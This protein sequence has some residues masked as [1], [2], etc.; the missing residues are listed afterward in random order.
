MAA[1][2]DD[3]L[4]ADVS[5]ARAAWEQ[6]GLQARLAVLK[7]AGAAL[8]AH[9]EA[10][11]ATLLRDGLSRAMARTY[12]DWIVRCARPPL[13]D[14]Y[15]E[16]FAR[17]M[18][19]QGRRGELLVRRPDGV[20]LLVLPGGSPTINAASLFSILLPGNGVVVR[21]PPNDA[22]V[23]L[24]VEEICGGALTRHGFD[25]SL[26][27][28]V[29]GSTRSFVDRFLSADD[30]RTVV[31]FGGG[32]AG[33][34]V[35][36]RAQQ[37]G[38][39]AVLELEGSGHLLVWRDGAVG[40]AVPSAL[41]AFD[42]SSTPCLVP[43]HLHVH[44]DAHEA[45][46]EAL[47]EG[48]AGLSTVQA[49]PQDGRLVPADL[50]GWQAA[51]DEVRPLGKV[52]A[53]GHRMQA[54]GTPD[55]DGPYA[56]P[57]VVALDAAVVSG[58]ALR[59]F[60]EEIR[61]PLLPVVR[62]LGT[63]AEIAESMAR[64]AGASPFALR[65]SVWTEDPAQVRFFAQRLGHVGLLLFNDDHARCPDYAAP[66]GGTRRSG[67]PH[68]ENH[69]FWAKTSHLQ[70][71]VCEGLD[72]AG[73]QGVGEA[74]G[75]Q[76]A[77]TP[78]VGLAIDD[79]VATLTLQRPERHN[80]VDAALVAD[81]S[82]VLD[83]LFHEPELCAVVLRGQGPS[84]CSGGDLRDLRGLDATAARAFMMQ[85]TAVFRRLAAL[86]VP[87]IAA[88]HGFCLGGGFELALHC[89]EIIASGD[90]TLG[91][92]ET[93][94]G[95]VTTAGSVSRLVEAVGS[96]R[97]RHLLLTGRRITGREAHDMGLLTTCCEARA[98]EATVA[99]H[100]A[101]YRRL[102]RGSVAA[103]KRLVQ[104]ETAGRETASWIREV[105]TFEGLVRRGHA[106]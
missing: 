45:F 30:V 29:T 64:L 84:F 2:L 52:L 105:E 61:F 106:L 39:K 49:D 31:F 90:A 33:R 82:R 1:V 24:I 5:V 55:P 15:A 97:A 13:L 99:A 71:I 3:D 4:V 83:G 53:G 21:A 100:A 26:V 47:L 54:D 23:R 38:R 78:R 14:A 77:A 62:H 102:P 28:V 89:D 48:V 70:G 43:K 92:P 17:W 8:A 56:A 88:V 59:C 80:A 11:E 86:E 103:M 58:H 75:L 93:G 27:R 7:D 63:D 6:A 18:G 25:P 40:G 96:V 32:R 79:G 67:G 68:G 98:F 16:Q 44:A 37:L 35:A 76:P 69:L 91:F 74:L 95:F 66:W 22:G 46:V 60:E 50:D 94:V 65:A 85:A 42:A 51:L 20:V 101:A 81:L 87:V 9:R 34:A 72:E 57:T 10:L 104:A 41:R 36:E 19:T 12:G 73:R